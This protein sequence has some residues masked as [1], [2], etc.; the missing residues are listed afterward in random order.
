[1]DTIT[2]NTAR[3]IIKAIELYAGPMDTNNL[4]SKIAEQTLE[5]QSTVA[6][7]IEFINEL[8]HVVPPTT[9]SQTPPPPPTII[10]DRPL[11]LMDEFAYNYKVAK[12]VLQ[13][14]LAGDRTI[15]AEETR[16]SLKTISSFMEQ[17]LKLQE[18]LYN[19]Q[20]MQRFQDAVLDTIATIDP[21]YRDT[22]IERLLNE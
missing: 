16:K 15:D 18:R 19:T 8:K 17:A 10:D 12:M 2:L 11:D 14:S 13:T 9:T 4:I 22:I 3:K 7:V 20:Q 1:M 5:T 21:V 6:K